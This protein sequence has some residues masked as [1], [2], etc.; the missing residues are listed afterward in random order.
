MSIINHIFANEKFFGPFLVIAPLS[1]PFLFSSLVF[2]PS[3]V[4]SIIHLIRIPT[5]N[6]STTTKA[7]PHWKREFEGWTDMNVVIYN[8]NIDSR[9]LIRQNEWYFPGLKVCLIHSLRNSFIHDR[10][11]IIS[12][13]GPLQK[14]IPKFNVL[15]TTDAMAMK[16]ATLLSSFDW[17]YLAVDEAHRLKNRVCR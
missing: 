17:K 5:K 9:K 7:I 2:F 11:A 16:D 4:H 14:S 15:V 10:L 8:G 13:F 1:S 6:E 12:H 3:F